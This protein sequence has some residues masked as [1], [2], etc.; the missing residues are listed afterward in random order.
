MKSFLSQLSQQAQSKLRT[1]HTY[2]KV[3]GHLNPVYGYYVLPF[4]VIV[5]DVLTANVFEV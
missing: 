4:V 2:T 5:C 3:V 1:V